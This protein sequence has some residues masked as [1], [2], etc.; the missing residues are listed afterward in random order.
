[1]RRLL[2]PVAVAAILSLRPGPAAA[3]PLDLDLARLGAPS[4]AVWTKLAEVHGVALPGSDAALLASEAKTRFA[5]LSAE[6]A[7]ALSS[8]I[9]T[10][11]STTGY[12][13]FDVDLEAAYVAVH[14]QTVGS[15]SFGSSFEP[16]GPWQTR[17]MTPHELFLPSVHVRK[18]L[19]FSL[20]LGGRMIYLSQSSYFGAQIEGKWALNEGFHVL[21]DLAVRVAHTQLFG[22][23]DW[24]LGATDLDLMISKRFGVNGVTSFTPYVAARFTY[25]GASSETMDFGPARA[26]GATVTDP[27]GDLRSTQAAFPKLRAGFYR[28]TAGLR[29]T[30]HVVSLA[31]E[32]TYFGGAT[33]DGKANPAADEYPDFRLASSWGGALKAGWEF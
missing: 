12:L 19:P 26:G 22:Q 3:E 9:L 21:P 17:S 15:T 4:E 20:E 28:T 8:A 32:V 13:G 1:M 7:L 5:I 6:T 24:N 27:A 25:V 11:A 33:R 16:R 10:P 18:A 29:F 31:G 2:A 14:P 30:A 23:R